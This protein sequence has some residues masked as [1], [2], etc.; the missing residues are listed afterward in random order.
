MRQ[1]SAAKPSIPAFAVE[2]RP[3]EAPSSGID[4]N[5]KR[6]TRSEPARIAVI[7]RVKNMYDKY[8]TGANRRIAAASAGRLRIE[9]PDSPVRKKFADKT[10]VTASNNG[11]KSR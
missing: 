3:L 9:D 7:C 1:A 4:S 2:E 5:R 10:P 6:A 11:Q 8:A